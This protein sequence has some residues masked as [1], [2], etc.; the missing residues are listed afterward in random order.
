M[1]A[2]HGFSPQLFCGPYPAAQTQ[3]LPPLTAS[4]NGLFMWESLCLFIKPMD[5]GQ[6]LTH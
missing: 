3:A 5:W 1:H 2:N 4:R 6:S